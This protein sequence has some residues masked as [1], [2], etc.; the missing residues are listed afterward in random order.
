MQRLFAVLGPLFHEVGEKGV[1]EFIPH[2]LLSAAALGHAFLKKAHLF[3]SVVFQQN[4]IRVAF[5]FLAALSSM[6]PRW[7]S[8]LMTAWRMMS[9]MEMK[10][11]SAALAIAR[12]SVGGH[13][14]ETNFSESSILA[15]FGADKQKPSKTAG[16]DVAGPRYLFLTLRGIDITGGQKKCRGASRGEIC[17]SH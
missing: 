11:R 12:A 15:S 17:P 6:R 16:H 2:A 8:S 1:R 10:S 9:L 3:T 7:R 13:R 4:D 14:K 5:Q